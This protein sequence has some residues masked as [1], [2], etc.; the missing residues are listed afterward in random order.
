M[1]NVEV[2]DT[3]LRDG[4]QALGISLSLNDKLDIAEKLNEM[5]V[6]Y[7]EGGWP[8]PTNTVD[9]QFYARAAK[10]NLKAKIAAFG[11]T[12]RPKNDV[13]NDPFMKMLI[14]TGAPVATI[15][16]KTWDL[17]VEK[18]INTTL[19][20][21]LA[22]VFDSVKFL[23]SHMDEVIYDAEH[24]FDGYKNNPEYSMKTLIAAQDAGAD[25]I[26]LCDTNGGLLPDEFVKI[27]RE[28]K[29]KLNVKL[30]I[31]MHNDSGCGD[32]MSCLGVIEGAQHVQGTINGLGERCGN[33]N[34]CTI[35]PNLQLKRGFELVTAQQL[36]NLTSASVYIAET[37]NVT[38][39]IRHP[40]VGEAAFSHKAG[41]HAD[42]VR[43][44]SQSF[45]HISP[46][47]VGNSRQFVVSD[48]AGSSTIL[49][50]LDKIQP[51]MD[52]KDPSVKKLLSVTKELESKGYQ[53]EAAE[54][55]FE[56]LAREVLGQFE[57]PFEVIGFRV[58]EEKRT[59]GQ[60]YSEATIKVHEDGIFEHT[61]AEGDG[62][63]NA[64]DN[65]L[66]KSLMKFFPS[67][68]DV[69]LEDFKV[70]VLDERSGTGAKVRV[71]IESTDKVDRWGTVGVSTNI[72]EA[73]W[74]ALLDS[75]KYKLMKDA[76]SKKEKKS[77]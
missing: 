8:N 52:K 1:H 35:I 32:A 54:G 36:K 45:E 75:I 12:R 76:L 39:N 63:V 56:L 24:F 15:F 25:C 49:E 53:F 42:G 29:S 64:L 13:E 10:M 71:L 37:A 5:G 26:V 74:L 6:H 18:V 41:A 2:Y 17:H 69:K 77:V 51:G 14:S 27:F 59:D 23:K 33:A 11:S 57:E 67:L 48:Q 34:L 44:V 38:P 40:Y 16:G 50:K 7:I 4:N 61:A 62:P 20:E 22:M 43:K 73:S 47:L 19:E 28:V 21:N 58:I 70:R 30:G 72:I 68:E 60:V 9:T 3:T 46:E 55:S 31:H 66:R 65:A